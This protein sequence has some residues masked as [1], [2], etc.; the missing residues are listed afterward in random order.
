MLRLSTLVVSVVCLAAIIY[1]ASCSTAPQE[2]VTLNVV[3]KKQ[4]VQIAIDA[5]AEQAIIDIVSPSGIGSAEFEIS[6]Q[7][8]PEKIVLRFHLRGLEE[9][10]FDYGKTVVI[11]SVASAPGHRIRQHQRDAGSIEL[12]PILPNSPYWMNIDLVAQEGM[13]NT[14]PLQSGY[15]QVEA[16][17]DFIRSQVRRFRI[18]W[19]DLYR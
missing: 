10:Q 13:S 8:L 14:I 19:V 2:H 3:S 5:S 1:L 18:Q 16:P 9:I 12:E 6:S 7:A 17:E 4:D 15:I 11:G